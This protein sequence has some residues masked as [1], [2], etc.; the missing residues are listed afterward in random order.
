M[1]KIFNIQILMQKRIKKISFII[2]PLM[3]LI[4]SACSRENRNHP[5]YTYMNDMAPSEAYEYYS[6]NPNFKDG[7]TAQQPVK[8]TIHRGDIPH[9]YPKTSEGQKLAGLELKNPLTVTKKDLEI[10]KE[11]YSITCVLC[12]GVTGRG[13][14]HLVS[15]GKF[16]TDVT[17]LVDEFVQN[18]PSGEIYHVITLGSVS[19]YMG[20][21]S[22]QIKPKD[23][24]RI[25]SYIKNKLKTD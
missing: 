11:I 10:A 19:G 25:V 21:H 2:L 1:L 7:K 23:R 22:A 14:G 16:T 13:D 18:K 20:S 8:G 9:Q 6:G 15:S 4:I 3:L 5:G 17:S 24:W 12:H